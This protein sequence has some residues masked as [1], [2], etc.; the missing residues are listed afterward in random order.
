LTRIKNRN[1]FAAPACCLIII[2]AILLGIAYAHDERSTR[3]ERDKYAPS[4]Q[5]G[6]GISVAVTTNAVYTK[7]FGWTITKTVSPKTW[8]LCPGDS[9]TS[10]YTVSVNKDDGIVVSQLEG[11]VSVT[12]TG[13]VGTENL[14]ITAKVAV[15]PGGGFGPD[16]LTIPVD[17]ASNPVLDPNETGTYSYT[18]TIPSTDVQVG[19]TYK[20]TVHATITNHSGH[21]GEPWD[22]PA[23]ATTTWPSPTLVHNCI[24]VTDINGQLWTTC[25]SKTWTYSK[26]FTNPA[27]CEAN[28]NTATITY[29]DDSMTGP[30]AQ[31][32]VTVNCPS[33][34]GDCSLSIGYWM[35]HAGLGP[36]PDEVTQY[37]PIWLGT[38]NGAKSVQV[39]TAV[40][41]VNLLNYNDDAS[42]GIN[43]LYGQLLAAKLNIKNGVSSSTIDT[44]ISD[45]DAFLATNNAGDWSSLSS[46]LK[47]QVNAWKNTLD[48]YNNGLLPGGPTPCLDLLG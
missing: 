22:T 7:T 3:I 30:S 48:Q 8:D 23:S 37:L 10:T 32:T 4:G 34:G 39:T 16:I 6:T 36:Q 33:C 9:G 20:V 28:T 45:A 31:A 18:I 42:N 35:N 24:T 29:N 41:A 1:R 44:V 38:P 43:R 2:A 27:N 25:D 11:T 19:A 40:Q 47:D 12:N 46:A 13:A 17:T 15:N 14:A 5:S 21:I 26:T